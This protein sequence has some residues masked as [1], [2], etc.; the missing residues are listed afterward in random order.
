MNNLLEERHRDFALEEYARRAE[1][2]REELE[3]QGMDAV[4]LTHE[5]NV[6]WLAGYHNLLTLR[7]KWM[8]VAV[9]FPREAEN[10]SVLMCATDATGTGVACVD[11]VRFWDEKSKPPFS[12]SASPVGVLAWEIRKRGLETKRIGMELGEGMRVDLSHNDFAALRQA[13]PKMD[14]V[15]FAPS[16][17][18][19]RSIKSHLEVEKLAQAA[20]ITL[21]GYRK[22]FRL[23]REG[24]TEKELAAIICSR[25]LELGAQAIGFCGIV[26]T[27]RGVRYAHVGP[28]DLPIR[29]G[30]IVNVD[31]G[32]LV[33][34]YWADVFRMVCIGEPTSQEE[35]SVV[36]CIIEAKQE[37]IAATR[38]GVPCGDVYDAAARVFRHAGYGYLL[39]DTSIGHGLGLDMHE[40]PTLSQGSDVKLE[41]NM[42]LCVEPWTLDYCDWS[43]GRNF[44]DTVRVT[45][46]GTEL[47]TPGLDNLVIV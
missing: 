8:T 5:P 33:N 38:P 46:S 6:R 24:M 7:M 28:S 35:R 1:Q 11:E 44:E 34:G 31:G 2:V 21:E 29:R 47:L 40:L 19:L 14:L 9:L 26:S 13:L 30:Q 39:G 32:C 36:Q 3:R 43:M 20:D 18:R 25:W 37:A 45:G 15:D 17:W 23:L 4:V 22:G 10:G 41:Q 42:V 12:G 16:L 27:P